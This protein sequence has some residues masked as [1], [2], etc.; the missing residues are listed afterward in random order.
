MT[1]DLDGRIGEGWSGDAPNGSHVNVVLAVL[2]IDPE[3]A[4]PVRVWIRD[5]VVK[6]DDEDA[7]DIARDLRKLGAGAKPLLA[8]LTVMLDSKNGYV[9]E[10]AVVTLG[11]IGEDARD[12][13]PKLKQLA[14]KD[15]N[16]HIRTQATRAIKAIA[17][18]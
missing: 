7:Y 8:E 12:A 3:T 13:L 16:A 5:H 6:E 1:D 10:C 17:L 9:R 15:T 11:A 14:E 18:K 2:A 4:K